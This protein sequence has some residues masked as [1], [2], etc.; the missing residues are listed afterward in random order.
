MTTISESYVENL[1]WIM[2]EYNT[3]EYFLEVIASCVELREGHNLLIL[4][5]LSI[6]YTYKSRCPKCKSGTLRVINTHC[7]C[8]NRKCVRLSAVTPIEFLRKYK[9]MS[10]LNSILHIAKI[11]NLDLNKEKGGEE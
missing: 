3:R 5:D 1:L 4:G 10:Y 11:F 2:D 7:I 9:G 8:D 6:P